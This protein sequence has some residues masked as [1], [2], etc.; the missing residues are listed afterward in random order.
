[1]RDFFAHIT[2]SRE[3]Q[4][5]N[6]ALAIFKD[7]FPDADNK[8]SNYKGFVIAYSSDLSVDK[9]PSPIWCGERGAYIFIFG[10]YSLHEDLKVPDL[11]STDDSGDI[12]RLFEAHGDALFEK[13]SG[14]F[15][16][17]IYYP[18]E[19][20]FVAVTSK[21]G[22]Y[23]L[24]YYQLGKDFMVSSRLGVFKNLLGVGKPDFSVIMQHC[25]YN[26]PVSSKT[27]IQEVYV[28]PAGSVLSFFNQNI[29]INNYWTIDQEMVYSQSKITFNDSVDLL[30]EVLDRIIRRQCYSATKMGL[31]LTGGWDGRLL[32]AYALK[33]LSPDQIVLYSHGT[34]ESPDVKLPIATS[35]K[36]NLNYIPVL[37]NDPE[38]LSQQLH[39]AT[40]TIKY[41]DGIRPVTRLH[42]LYNMSMLRNNYGISIIM[43][44]NGG[45]N[46]LKST[47]YKPCTVFNRFVIEL[48]ESDDFEGTLREQYEYCLAGFSSLFRKVD[49]NSFLDSFDQEYFQSLFSIRNKNRRF[50]HFLVSEIERKYFGSEIQSY[51]HLV[52]NYSPFF[53]DEFIKAL[54][55]TIFIEPD[56]Y[57]GI[58]KS[59]KISLLYARLIVR[60]N[61]KLAK[62]PTDRGFSMYD[63]SN[64]I[65]FPRM[66]YKYFKNKVSRD[67]S[68]D[69]FCNK[70]IPNLY[71][72]KF[73]HKPV[74]LDSNSVIN[75][76]FVE[77]YISVMSFL[78]E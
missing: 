32:L 58:L 73:L 78:N 25:L 52:K 53:D 60:N 70:N 37:L 16:A 65:L 39:W 51:K 2:Q 59:H 49:W 56:G 33:Y 76:S 44:G 17:L 63:V 74:I 43:S 23:P 54:G 11:P 77:N 5:A 55:K 27:F 14:H 9:N 24:Y 26:Y 21:L 36:F 10:E 28:Q 57:K 7:L 69:Y 67:K 47:N 40:D 68:L 20:K 3:S 6:H 48:I 38:Y 19:N 18:D 31:S 4:H 34:L 30:D 15:N 8:I 22:L 62:E 29:S 45:S 50:L 41:S 71:A 35:K 46:L 12:V 75:K 61:K 72:Q 66:L 64:P 13:I 1:M 42:Y